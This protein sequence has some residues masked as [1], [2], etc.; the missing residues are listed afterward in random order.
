MPDRRLQQTLNNLKVYCSNRKAGCEW[1]DSLGKLQLHLNVAADEDGQSD[2]FC[3]CL[4][5]LIPCSHCKTRIQRQVIKEHETKECPKRPFLCV[6]CNKYRSSYEDVTLKHAPVC[7]AQLVECPYKCGAQIEHRCVE[8]HSVDDCPLY[9][10]QCPF[11][12]AGCKVKLPR[13]DM[14][15][16]THVV[17]D[18]L[19]VHM[20]LQQETL[21]RELGE[22]KT[23][24]KV[25]RIEH[26]QLTELLRRNIFRISELEDE[27]ETLK[28]EQLPVR[29]H[30]RVTPLYFLLV[31]F[32]S[33]KRNKKVWNSPPFYTHPQGYKMCLDVCAKLW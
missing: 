28:S 23:E 32:S 18:S 14:Y 20:T 13:K 26:D 19:A 3:G 30:F 6:H 21:L 10:I 33:K 5:E 2:K 12:N 4:F 31:D 8:S 16:P 27:V 15:M 25:Q 1:L 29:A 22:L 24:I 11:L 9:E 17:V 7:P